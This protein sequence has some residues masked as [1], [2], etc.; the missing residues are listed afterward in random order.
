MFRL[1]LDHLGGDYRNA[2]ITAVFG[3]E[4][5]SALPAQW[6]RHFSRIE[7]AWTDFDQYRDHKY[8]ATGEARFRC[9]RSDADLVILC[10]ADTMLLRTLSDDVLALRRGGCIGGVMAHYHFPWAH[11]SGDSASDWNAISKVVLG[12][13][14]STPYRYSLSHDKAKMVCPFYVNY[15]FVVGT[16]QT[17]SI[18]HQ[19]SKTIAP[20]VR[21]VIPNFFQGQIILSL[22]VAAA[23]L[24]TV[25]LPMRSNFPNDPV[26]DAK[27]P[28]ELEN[29]ELLHYLRHTIFDR[30]KIFTDRE[31]FEN[32]LSLPL[33]GSNKIFQSYVRELTAAQFPF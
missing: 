28:G 5:V 20:K 25:S 32:F 17:L 12:R 30:H 22:S 9:M 21:K 4:T 33:T 23:G 24:E 16:P 26:A 11:A 18:V 1:A 7:V 14:I 6:R 13:E 27:Y 15:G 29:I 3:H 10:D 19:H 31:N 2:H 8:F